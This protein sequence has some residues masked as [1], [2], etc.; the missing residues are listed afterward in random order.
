MGGSSVALKGLAVFVSLQVF[1]HTAYPTVNVRF[2][3]A[4][5]ADCI[6]AVARFSIS[7]ARFDS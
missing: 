1:Y 4:M 7:S 6:K 3:Y 2:P 5:T